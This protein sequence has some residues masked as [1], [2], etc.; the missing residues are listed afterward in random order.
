MLGVDIGGS[1]IKGAPVDVRTGE[2]LTARY[3]LPTPLPAKPKAVAAVVAELAEHFDWT[4]PA[5][6]T[7]PAV[8]KH[9]VVAT[10]VHVHSS[11]IGTDAAELFGHRLNAP[12]TVLNDA[13]AA[14]IAEMAFGAGKGRD[15][16]VVMLTLGTGIG[17]AVFVDG[18]LVRNTEL[19][20]LQIRGK[21]AER[22][23]AASVREHKDLSW[24]EWAERL[25]EYFEALEALLWPDL[26][27][28][29]GGVSK[30]HERFFPYL[31]TR[32][33]LVPAAL[34]NDAGIVGAALAASRAAS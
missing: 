15:H 33:E 2:L 12:V 24:E 28:I 20:H 16:V 8:V 13:D 7:F 34:A 30:D 25:N 29:G 1:G 10:A 32:A 27:I 22:R 31:R 9:G 3:R 14:G 21:D 18:V 19:G 11:W 17:S 6:V 5:G 4:G 26:V 23:A